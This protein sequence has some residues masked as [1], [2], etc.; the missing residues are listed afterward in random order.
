MYRTSIASSKDHEEVIAFLERQSLLGNAWLIWDISTVFQYNPDGIYSLLI[1]RLH[2][3][4]VGVACILDYR[5][6]P[7][8]SSGSKPDHDYDSRIDAAN[9]DAVKA[10]LEA[11]PTD[12][13]GNF[14]IFRPMIQEY[15]RELPD[16][17]RIEGDLYFSV[18]A[19]RFRP[20]TGES[21]IE[22]TANDVGLFE[23]CEKKRSWEHSKSQVF[24]IMRDDRV[25]TSARVGAV[26]PKTAKAKRRIIAIID[27]YTETKYRRMGLGRQLVSHVTGKILNDGNVPIYWTE[28]ENIASQSLA[29]SLGYW[30]IGQMITYRWRKRA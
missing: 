11:F 22:L 5:K 17:K 24:A 6:I 18:S 20:V 7:P 9:R 27:L 28:P 30:Q 4:I 23:G 15:F 21:V 8:S 26:I 12:A 25:A 3:D 19:E 16:A 2:D 14:R 10:L 1:C 29:K 13:L